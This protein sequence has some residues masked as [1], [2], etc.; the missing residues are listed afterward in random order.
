MNSFGK[1]IGVV[2]VAYYPL[3]NFVDKV[4]HVKTWAAIVIIVDNTPEPHSAA[5]STYIEHANVKIVKNGT[6]LGVARA[7][8]QGFEVARALGYKWVI[9]FDQD[10]ELYDDFFS[11]IAQVYATT[12]STATNP[13]A[14]I[15]ANYID[16]NMADSIVIDKEN[17]TGKG[18]PA[19][20]VITSGSLIS[21]SIHQQLG[22]FDEKYFIDMVDYEFCFRARQQGCGV[23]KTIRPLMKHSIGRLQ[24][25]KLFLW[26]F[27]I[28]NHL[29]QRRYYIFR[30]SID[31][32]KKYFS[33]DFGWCL[34]IIFSYLPKVFIKACIFEERKKENLR[35]IMLGVLDGIFSR[36]SRK[37]L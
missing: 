34:F 14:V 35:Y 17:N 20:T 2:F 36:F 3:D 12:A 28:T 19:L 7:L 8:N 13:I 24:E 31:M 16:A 5:L 22:G 29:P 11:E 1:D 37:V 26:S 15:G 9:T 18:L 10:T 27:F 4:K 6:N 32:V 25:K 21:T 33:F 23:W 30:N